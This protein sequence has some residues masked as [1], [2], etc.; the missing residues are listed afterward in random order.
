M[1]TRFGKDAKRV[2]TLDE[3]TKMP[4]SAATD[5]EPEFLIAFMS[6]FMETVEEEID[7]Q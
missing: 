2:I 5:Y 3:Y 4:S 1:A 6:G 7:Q